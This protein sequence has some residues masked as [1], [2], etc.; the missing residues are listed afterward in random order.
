MIN[1]ISIKTRFGWVSVF[2]NKGKIFKVRFGKIRN[3]KRSK[4]LVNFKKKLLRFFAKKTF[5]I[6]TPHR[7][8]GND[9][10]KKIWVELKKIK[11][12]KTKTYNEIARKFKLSPRHIGKICGQ[13]NLV[14]I[15]PCHRIVRSDGK[16]GGFTSVGGIK[17]KR[18]LL[19]FEQKL[20]L[21][22]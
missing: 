10:Q 1:K 6:D 4:I 16:L 2:E 17:L 12:G 5:K 3:Q 15:I 11:I 19:E 13:N 7:M 18:K 22:D 14:L 9:L 20:I 21:N 8:Y